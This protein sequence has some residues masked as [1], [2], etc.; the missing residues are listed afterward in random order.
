MV[1]DDVAGRAAELLEELREPGIESLVADPLEVEGRRDEQPLGSGIEREPRLLDRL[2][3]RGGRDAGMDPRRRIDPGAD[4]RPHH[5]GPRRQAKRRTLA[6]RAEQGDGIAA[7]RQHMARVTDE[8]RQVDAAA[9]PH[10]G[11]DR[12]G[13]AEAGLVGGHGMSFQG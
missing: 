10:R 1:E 6:G 4:Q 7:L 9:L 8:T 3:H 12:A 11:G 2:M 13:E 5:R